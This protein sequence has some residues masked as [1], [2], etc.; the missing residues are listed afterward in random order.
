MPDL[1]PPLEKSG[2]GPALAF[3][4]VLCG[5]RQQALSFCDVYA[6][7]CIH[8]CKHYMHACMRVCVCVCVCVCMR[9]CV[10]LCTFEYPIKV[11]NIF[12]HGIITYMY[13]LTTNKTKFSYLRMSGLSSSSNVEKLSSEI[14]YP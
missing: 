11:Y 2:Y 9:V 4:F 10:C 5:H 1:E 7:A 13:F 14:L 8:M 3:H 12:L 6:S